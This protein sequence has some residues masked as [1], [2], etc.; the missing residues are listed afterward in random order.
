[1][2]RSLHDLTVPTFSHFSRTTVVTTGDGQT[3][4]YVDSDSDY[5]D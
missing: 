3:D 1:M 5:L 2:L 4:G